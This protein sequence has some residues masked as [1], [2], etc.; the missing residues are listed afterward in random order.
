MRENCLVLFVVQRVDAVTAVNVGNL[1][2]DAGSEVGQQEGGCVADFF[3]GNVAAQWV[4]GSDVAQEFAEI[5]D[6]GSGQGFDRACGD[7]VAADAF[8]AQAGGS[9][10]DA[11]FEAGFGHAHNVVVRNSTNGA[12]VAQGNDCGV[13]ALHHRTGGFCQRG[14]AVCGDF[15]SSVERFA[16]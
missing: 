9:E 10:A 15:V 1:A 12:Q 13:A 7:A 11:G 16:G 3:G 2:G 4:V 14:Q 6:A 8:F 5:G